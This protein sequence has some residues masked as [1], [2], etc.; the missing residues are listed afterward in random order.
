MYQGTGGHRDGTGT[1]AVGIVPLS[2]SRHWTC[3]RDALGHLQGVLVPTVSA[4]PALFGQARPQHGT[5]VLFRG[6][7]ASPS[8]LGAVGMQDRRKMLYRTHRG[9]SS[10]I[11][12]RSCPRAGGTRCW[13]SRESRASNGEHAFLARVSPTPCPCVVSLQVPVGAIRTQGSLVR[14][15]LLAGARDSTGDSRVPKYCHHKR[16]PT[17]CSIPMA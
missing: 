17:A 9:S 2:S 3:H 14:G 10:E 7:A 1:P 12:A 5:R 11:P 6:P 8:R 15:Q 16:D 13:L 4:I